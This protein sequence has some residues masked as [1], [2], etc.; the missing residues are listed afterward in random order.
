M[1]LV[2]LARHHPMPPL[3]WA[4][5]VMVLGLLTAP[6]IIFFVAWVRVSR[7]AQFKGPAL[8]GT[9]QL[10]S[11]ARADE[12]DPF[13]AAWIVEIMHSRSERRHPCRIGLRVQV[14]GRPP[15]DVTVTTPVGNTWLHKVQP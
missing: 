7:A 11:A 5:S 12:L 9:A 2:I 13:G 10:L 3:Q 1:D 14:P 15:Y 6:L 4:L 8:T